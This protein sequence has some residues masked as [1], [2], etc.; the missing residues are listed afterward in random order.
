MDRN[1]PLVAVEGEFEGGVDERS[2]VSI[3]DESEWVRAGIVGI[4]GLRRREGEEERSVE[5]PI[6]GVLT[7]RRI[8]V[9]PAAAVGDPESAETGEIA[10]SELAGVDRQGGAVALSTTDGVTWEVP[11]PGADPQVE[12]AIARELL[13]IGRVRR[14]IVAAR[15]DVDLAA[16]EIRAAAEDLNWADGLDRYREVRATL[17]DL[18][19]SVFLTESVHESALGPE[20]TSIERD[21][22]RAHVEL[23]V[24]R[25]GS[26]LT[27]GQQLMDNGDVE[28]AGAV[29]ETAYEDFDAATAHAA[30]LQR[31]DA[32]R[33]GDQRAVEERLER[34]GWEVEAVAAEPLRHAYEAKMLARSTRDPDETLEHWERAIHRFGAALALDWAEEER[35]TGVDREAVREELGNAAGQLLAVHGTLAR[36]NWD[37]G[38]E[39]LGADEPKPAIERLTTAIDHLERARELAAEFR[40]DAVEDL[41]RRLE[42]MRE[43]CRRVRYHGPPI[44]DDAPRRTEPADDDTSRPE[45]ITADELSEL[46]SRRSPGGP[47]GVEKS[48]GGEVLIEAEAEDPA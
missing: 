44:P 15:N 22:E 20:L 11:L 1:K 18:C 14:R 23:L 16:G 2:L 38:V 34:L 9:L 8:V 7:D 6:A 42:A 32:F 45:R 30:A 37:S 10:Y 21:L 35:F 43:G 5:T 40:P 27:L 39:H 28:Q 47:G 33:F 25:A 31:S 48:G 46:D 17:D 19:Q 29:L 41:E 26:R 3:T 12:D 13:W 36:T 4:E 24:E